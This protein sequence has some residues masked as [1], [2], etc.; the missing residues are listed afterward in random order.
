[1]AIPPITEM[2]SSADDLHATLFRVF[3]RRDQFFIPGREL[4]SVLQDMADYY[5]SLPEEVK[6]QGTMTYAD[7]PPA[8]MDNAVTK[9][10]DR[11][12]P[13]W[14]A[15]GPICQKRL[16]TRREMLNCSRK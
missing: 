2:F 10:F 8:A 4:K 7:Y 11:K 3:A 14:R 6:R 15:G 16:M 13:N 12:F 1:M 5:E 9:V